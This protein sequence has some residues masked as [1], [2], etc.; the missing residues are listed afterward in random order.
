MIDGLRR[1]WDGL[2]VFRLII[3]DLSNVDDRRDLRMLLR[4]AETLRIQQ[5]MNRN[6]GLHVDDMARQLSLMEA[7]MVK[8]REAAEFFG[9]AAEILAKKVKI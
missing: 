6:I 5:D 9:N 2:C 3:L 1:F 4:H 8:M 7:E